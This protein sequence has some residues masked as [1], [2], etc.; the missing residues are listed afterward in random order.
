MSL[1]GW[2]DIP[3][4]GLILDA[5]NAA[6]YKTGTWRSVRPVWDESKCIHCHLCWLHCPDG[7]ILVENEKMVGI[8]YD[9]CK[10][11]G[12]CASICPKK[13]IEMKPESLFEGGE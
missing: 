11:C 13:A 3:P 7:S 1:K 6:L 2:K 10:G 9:Y 8:S 4:A 12:I 5:G